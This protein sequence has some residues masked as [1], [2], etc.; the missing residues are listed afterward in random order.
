MP[1]SLPSAVSQLTESTSIALAS[2]I[3]G[4]EISTPLHP[5]P[6]LTSYA[7]QGTGTTPIGLLHGF[8]S[9]LLEYRRLFP[10][11]AEHHRVYAIDLLG[12]G[13]TNRLP[14]FPYSPTSIHTHLYY[15]WK[16]LIRQPMILV[17][18][19]MGGATALEFTLK[20][21]ELVKQLVLIDSV[22]CTKPP[23]I[24]KFLVPPLGNL[25]TKFLSLPQVRRGVSEKAY[26]DRALA[27]E[28]ALIC[29]SLHLQSPYWSEALINFTRSGGYSLLLDRLSEIQ[30]QTLIIW[31]EQDRILGTKPA[32]QLEQ[33]LPNSQLHWIPNCGHVPHLETPQIVADLILKFVNVIE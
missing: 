2:Q 22:G 17:G 20:Y 29:A 32:R 14:D 7:Q 15:T 8:D 5:Q 25:A 26:F 6:I 3:Q 11:L 31:G 24:G 9:S 10:R 16:T 21:P 1:L 30:Q 27:T 33:A 28:D 12:F 18:A 4:V 23:Q 13:F 19:S